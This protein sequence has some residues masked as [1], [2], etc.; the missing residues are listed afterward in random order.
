MKLTVQHVD[1]LRFLVTVGEHAVVVDAAPED[2][3]GGTS[4]SAPQLFAAALGACI[5]EFVAN[6]CRLRGVPFEHL[7]LELEYEE[8]KRPRRIGEVRATIHI[9]P[10][11]DEATKRRLLGVAR[12][13]TLMNTLARPPEVAIQFITGAADE[14]RISG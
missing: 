10:E 9:E 5:L 14:E 1:G 8:V 12:H 4:T 2:G 7:S 11:P 3:G 13:V 6:S